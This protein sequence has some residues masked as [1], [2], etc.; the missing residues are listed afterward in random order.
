MKRFIKKSSCNNAVVGNDRLDTLVVF[1]GESH[2]EPF[3]S[4]TTKVDVGKLNMS[5][6]LMKS[7]LLR[8]YQWT[9]GIVW[10]YIETSYRQ[11]GTDFISMYT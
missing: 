3:Q 2:T 4:M 5:E 8:N 6:L 11:P 9:D 7:D 1:T 10:N